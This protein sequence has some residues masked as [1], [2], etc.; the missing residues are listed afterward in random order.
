MTEKKKR[1]GDVKKAPPGYYTAKDAQNKL[2]LNASTFRYY[3]RQG[4]IKRHVPPLKSEGFY[5]K[6]E[7][8]RLATEMALFLH[9]S[10]EEETT[11]GIALPDD[12]QGIYDVLDSFKWQTAPVA[13]RL[14]WYKVNP[15]IDYVVRVGDRVVGYVHAVPF[16]PE[17]L[18]AIM[19]G[20]K[21]AWHMK[22]EDILPYTSGEYDLYV[23]AAVRQ[24]V[25]NHTRLAF[26]LIAGFMSFLEELATEHGII[27]RHFYAVSDQKD[28]QDLC[29]A[30][31]FVE[32][33]RQEGDRYPRYML[34]LET[35]ESRFA[36]QYR[37]CLTS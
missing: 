29:K 10:S 11:V 33:K 27:I 9:T 5:S 6:K 19:A 28:G 25:P 13:L 4:K 32:Q 20:K 30:L 22:P 34:D 3:V 7:I 12:T 37:E 23:G 21:R 2:G 18:E 26:R 8:D 36:R 24:D 35:C 14:S 15:S 1:G 17:A 16:A 31:G